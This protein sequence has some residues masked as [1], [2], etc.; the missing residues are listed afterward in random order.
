MPDDLITLATR[1][2]TDKWGSHWY[3]RHYDFHFAPLRERPINLL[4]IGIGG[5]DDP[6]AGGESLRMWR[7]YFPHAAIYGLDIADKSAHD[8]ARI[9]TFVGSQDD[10]EVLDRLVRESGGFDVI[11]DDGSHFCAHVIASFRHL[12]PTLKHGGIYAIED[13]QTSYWPVFGGAP[14]RDGTDAT[15]MGFLKRL[16][17]GLNHAEFGDPDY[18]PDV[19][20][21]HIVSMHFYHNLCFLYKGDNDEGSNLLG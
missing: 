15:S 12:F 5:Y 18:V 14:G 3:A 16:A 11:I 20:D 10:P 7:D 9:R 17:D 4:E 6:K 1:H 2:R 8:E 19:F 21:K 13:L